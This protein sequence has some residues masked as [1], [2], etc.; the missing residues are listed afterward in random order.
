[1]RHHAARAER[2]LPR[3]LGRVSPSSGGPARRP[4]VVAGRRGA[5]DQ[6]EQQRRASRVYG[7]LPNVPVGG[8]GD[9]VRGAARERARTPPRTAASCRRWRSRSICA[10]QLVPGVG[11]DDEEHDRGRDDHHPRDPCASAATQ[12]TREPRGQRASVAGRPPLR[13][14]VARIEA[15]ADR[16]IVT[17][18]LSALGVP[19]LAPQVAD[20]DVDDVGAWVVLIAPHRAQDL[21]A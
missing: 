10:A 9:H 16:P 3:L 11:V 5:R 20:V 2:V 15:V 14:L 19:E 21:L 17:I 8:G 4:R 18:G 13:R 7:W 6:H 12:A 1:M